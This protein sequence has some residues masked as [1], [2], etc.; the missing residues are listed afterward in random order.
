VR[1]T[2]ENWHVAYASYY[3]T[4]DTQLWYHQLELNAGPP[5][6]PCFVQLVNKRVGSPLIDNPIGEIA[7]LRRNGNVDD[8]AKRF[9]AL[10]CRDTVIT[11]AHPVQLFLTGLGKPLR[12]DVALHRPPTFDDAIMLPRAYEQ[13]ETAL[14]PLALC[15]HSSWRARTKPSGFATGR[16]GLRVIVA[17][18]ERVHSSGCCKDLPITIG[19]ELFTLDYFGLTLGSHEMVLGVQW[20]ESLGPIL[21]DFTACTIVFVRNGHR[22]C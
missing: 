4:N 16:A 9:M 2:L 10:S 12:I 20:L 8:F 22:I 1:R 17:N 13:R 6:W 7:L 15:Q 19:D 18:D 3:L 21:W 11:E 14:S 5:P